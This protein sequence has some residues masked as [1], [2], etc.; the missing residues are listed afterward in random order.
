MGNNLSVTVVVPVYNVEKYLRRCVDSLL[1]QDYKPLEIILVDDGSPDNSGEICDEYAG[2]YTN[3]SVIHKPNG[4][5]SSARKAG[6]NAAKGDTIAFV[7]SDDYVRPDYIRKL[8]EP[9]ANRDVQLSICG[10]A[11]NNNHSS[12]SWH[13]PYKDSIIENC[14]IEENYLLPLLGS[15][16]KNNSI[17]IPGFVWIRMYRRH[18]I[19]KS[20]FVSEREYFTEDILMN[21]L[22]ARRMTGSI[23]VVNE[24][25]YY[26]CVNPGSLTLRYRE[27]I[28]SKLMARYEF[29]CRIARDLSSNRDTIQERLDGN[30]ASAVTRSVY[31]IGRIRDYRKFKSE[32]LRIFE[33]PEVRELFERDVW[34][35][36]ATWSKIIY[37]T[38][39]TRSYFLLYKLLKTRKVL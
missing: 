27:D 2:K 28:F 19:E 1:A 21:L 6:W 13:L 3:I 16:S 29:C 39:R 35:K 14:N 17:N 4:G 5:L 11:T 20:D 38:Y 15:S 31:N 30:L 33:E 10:Y 7:D 37:V 23:A 25:L 24:P 8:T 9:F 32:L 12:I 18:L 26:Y 22:Y 36:K 34:P